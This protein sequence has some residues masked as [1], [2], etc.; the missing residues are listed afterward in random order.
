MCTLPEN[1]LF[2]ISK[3]CQELFRIH[4]SLSIYLVLQHI[5]DRVALSTC[6]L[7]SIQAPPG[8]VP[9]PKLVPRPF[10]SH[11]NTECN[12]ARRDHLSSLELSGPLTAWGQYTRFDLFERSPLRLR[13]EC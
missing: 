6:T 1:T 11:I 9:A 10:D 5:L 8:Q 13:H 2:L 3:H 4:T 12:H 7:A